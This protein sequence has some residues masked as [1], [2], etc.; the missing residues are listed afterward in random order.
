MRL[1]LIVVALSAAIP[2]SACHRNQPNSAQTAVTKSERSVFTDSA[3][4]ARV[5]QPT[6][7]GES[8]RLVCVPKDQGVDMARPKKP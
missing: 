5:C 8:W 6:Q 1:G 2:V 3:M 7:P 4:H